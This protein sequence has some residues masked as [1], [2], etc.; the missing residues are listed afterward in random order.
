MAMQG[1]DTILT[2]LANASGAL[3]RT[4]RPGIKEFKEAAG[5]AKLAA[6]LLKAGETFLNNGIYVIC[7][8]PAGKYVDPAEHKIEMPE[9]APE[10]ELPQLPDLQLADFL[11]GND[12]DRKVAYESALEDLEGRVFD[13]RPDVTSWD[14]APWWTAFDAD[15]AMAWQKLQFAI[16][17]REIPA[18]EVPTDEE[19]ST[20]LAGFAA[21]VIP[22]RGPMTPE[23][24]EAYRAL[25]YD[26]QEQAEEDLLFELRTFLIANGRQ[27]E[28]PALRE[29]FN[30]RV[31]QEEDGYVWLTNVLRA[32][33]KDFT[34]PFL[35]VDCQVP[36]S[37]FPEGEEAICFRCK[38]KRD[39]KEKEEK[40]AAKE[41]KKAEKASKASAKTA[42]NPLITEEAI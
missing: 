33:G 35:C 11:A 38:H 26:A 22:A 34:W 39:Q 21:P 40:A 9:I 18:F 16:H 32:G 14:D 30:E 25:D 20:W 7:D 15:A 6:E 42:K 24:I 23:E 5:S 29:L 3:E 31:R 1:I 10:P 4:A 13:A 12:E 27:E 8:E 17:H 2:A 37:A 36:V 41:A 19:F 28:W